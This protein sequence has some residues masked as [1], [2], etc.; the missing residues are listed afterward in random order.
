MLF[1]A[2][3]VA[4]T[5][6]GQA[7][8]VPNSGMETWRS[9]SAGGV[10]FPPGPVV[11]IE[12]PTEW[13]GFDSIVVAYG[14]MFGGIAGF[15]SDWHQQVFE[16]NTFKNGGSASAKV[17]TRVQDSLGAFAGIL[18]SSKMDLDITALSSGTGDPMDAVIFEG[19]TPTTLRITTVSAW[20]AYF[21]GNDTSTGMPGADEG[22][23]N[24]QAVA[25]YGGA[26]TVIGTGM[27]IIT[28][29]TSF[30]QVTCSLTYTT[31]AFDI[32]KVRIIFMSS[33]GSGAPL[34]SSTLF[35]DDVTMMGEPQ[36]ASHLTA[37]SDV[38]R[39]YP[40]PANGTL[41]LDGPTNVGLSCAV[42]SVSGQL[43]TSKALNGA[44]KLDISG[45]PAGLYLY[46]IT[47]ASGNAVQTGKVTVV[48]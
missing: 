46:S 17:M 34:D 5:S 22:V 47:D 41:Y 38:V 30:T 11:P 40:N 2:A 29:S 32:N 45:L 39:V 24:V 20:V 3:A 48:E 27:V 13:F 12:A 8:P 31:H 28:P 25:T 14:E 23:M 37:K 36:W 19:G 26:D 15:G 10:G 21:P 6:F 42:S 4:F 33:G 9:N 43:V 35:V 18:S 44:D 1:A 16:E 7:V